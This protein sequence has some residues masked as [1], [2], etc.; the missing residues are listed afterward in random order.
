[1]LSRSWFVPD[2]GGNFS[3]GCGVSPAIRVRE[4]NM[5]WLTKNW[6][7]LL[8]NGVALLVLMGLL[9]GIRPGMSNES[10][11]LTTRTSLDAAKWAVRFLLLSLAM[12]PLNTYFGWRW[13]IKL[14]KPAGL[15][16]FG[17]AWLHFVL[18]ITTTGKGFGINW[19]EFP[20]QT[21]VTFGLIGLIILTSMALT[22]TRWA[23]KRL[24]KNWKRLHRLVYI[25]GVAIIIHAT[26]A[27]TKNVY[28]FD[29]QVIYEL[30]VYLII[31]VVL[32]AVRIPFVRSGLKR[33]Y[34]LRGAKRNLPLAGG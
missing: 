18:T 17:F 22:S 1:M 5:A 25:A 15:W 12:S 10:R 30:Q 24:G 9:S 2:A 19:L 3:A 26:T 27:N 21:F 31:L 28:F 13:A 14:R 8:L 20:L 16:V 6:R 33:L 11:D 34:A 4:D 7:W 23:M 32:L 29:P